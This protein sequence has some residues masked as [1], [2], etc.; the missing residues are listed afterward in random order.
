VAINDGVTTSRKATVANLTNSNPLAV[1]I[2]DGSGNQITSFGGGTQYTNGSAQATPVGT[3]ALGW[4]AT[5]VR[6]LSTDTSGKLNVLLT[7][8]TITGTVAVTQSGNWS[9]RTQDG[10]GTAIT[11]NST[12]TAATTGLDINIRSILNTAP[13]TAGKLDIKGADGDV[14]VRQATAGNLL[15][16]VNNRDGSGNGWTS[17]STTYTSKFAQDINLLGVL[18]TAFTTVGKVDVKGADGDVFVRQATAANL[19]ATVVQGT[20]ANLNATVVGTGTFA[21]QNTPSSPTTISNG[22][23]TVA[24]AGTRVTLASSTTV[25]SIVVKALN[26]NT[27]TI[28]VGNS[29]VASSNGL[30]LAAGESVAFDLT[31][32]NTVNLDSSVNGEGVTYMAVG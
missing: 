19:N 18:G 23:T 32:L 10:S 30:Q 11:S 7:S 12:A 27:G 28:Y 31:N 6:A 4:D 16:T 26:S 3:V 9:T 17:N 14:F 29:T 8:T 20:A 5:N 22:K 24:T 15:A 13:T 21:V 25:R 1:E 2:V